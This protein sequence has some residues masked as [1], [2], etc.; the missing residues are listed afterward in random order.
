MKELSDILHFLES[1]SI[2]RWKDFP[3]IDLYMDQVLTIMEDQ[4]LFPEQAQ[5]LSASMVNNYVKANLLSR[6]QK[7][8]YARDH[9]A[10]LSMIGMLKQVLPLKELESLF[11]SMDGEEKESY[12]LF[13][14]LLDK[15]KQALLED[16][17]EEKENLVLEMAIKSYLY[18]ALATSL[19]EEEK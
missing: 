2:R 5:S 15:S 7:K 3:D 18:Q 19:L 6:A 8:K 17:E 11:S 10:R 13:C 16:L 4:L 12:E 9:L 1:K 14:D